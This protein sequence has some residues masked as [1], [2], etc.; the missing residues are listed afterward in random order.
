MSCDPTVTQE[1]SAHPDDVPTLLKEL[2]NRMER[3]EARLALSVEKES[4]TVEEAAERLDRKPWTVRQWCN[5][6]QV[7]GAYKVHG[8]GRTGEWRIPHEELVR[9]QNRGPLPERACQS[10]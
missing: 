10:A 7:K 3:I 4:Y 1:T 6:G 5:K 9:L 2:I 8:K